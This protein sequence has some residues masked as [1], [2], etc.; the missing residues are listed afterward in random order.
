MKTANQK[1]KSDNESLTKDV[2][3]LKSQNAELKNEAINNKPAKEKKDEG[4]DVVIRV[5]DIP[6][7]KK[8]LAEKDQSE[9][10]ERKKAKR[11]R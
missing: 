2:G 10:D 6:F 4:G 11:K 7:I 1:L 9:L 8:Q 5:T 3:A